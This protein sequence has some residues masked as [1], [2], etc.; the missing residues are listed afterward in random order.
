MTEEEYNKAM[1]ESGNIPMRDVPATRDGEA[2]SRDQLIA[3]LDAIPA[4]MEVIKLLHDVGKIL[5]ADKVG[6]IEHVN[7]YWGADVRFIDNK[8]VPAGQTNLAGIDVKN[9]KDYPN[10]Y[11]E[12][13]RLYGGK[14][15]P[16]YAWA[17]HYQYQGD[18]SEQIYPMNR[19]IA[20]VRGGKE[21]GGQLATDT[22]VYSDD[23][24]YNQNRE[25]L[26][27]Y[28]YNHQEY[29]DH[30]IL[31]VYS[32]DVAKYL[33]DTGGADPDRRKM[34][35]LCPDLRDKKNKTQ[36]NLASIEEWVK[37]KALLRVY[38]DGDTWKWEQ[39]GTKRL[40]LITY[41]V[42]TKSDIT[43]TVD[44]L[45][46]EQAEGLTLTTYK[47][48]MGMMYEHYTATGGEL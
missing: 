30:D 46:A 12:T 13:A 2:P 35:K 9:T 21:Y 43:A 39:L 45:K 27:T 40:K 23:K 38:R 3:Q 16:Q 11:I 44:R 20:Y 22:E 17:N 48:L 24:T 4:E 8:E 14:W 32:D 34:N 25:E 18:T 1:R 19:Y 29:L 6:L 28:Y 5:T 33:D 15:L 37:T 41:P 42:D 47:K 10:L 36:Y 26:I 7:K 31:F